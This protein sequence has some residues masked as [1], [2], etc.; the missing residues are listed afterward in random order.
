MLEII[1]KKR[2]TFFQKVF[3]LRRE[4]ITVILEDKTQDE[5]IK[6]KLRE[7][8]TTCGEAGKVVSGRFINTSDENEEIPYGVIVTDIL[9]ENE[10][11]TVAKLVN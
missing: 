4:F 11:T 9:G 2:R 8:I 6:K 10:P 3:R 1:I 7:Y 5:N